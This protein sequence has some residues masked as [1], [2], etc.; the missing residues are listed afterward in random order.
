MFPEV[1]GSSPGHPPSENAPEDVDSAEEPAWPAEEWPNFWPEPWAFFPPWPWPW[2]CIPAPGLPP[3]WWLDNPAYDM[4]ASSNF[5]PAWCT[6][7]PAH[8]I[9]EPA[10]VLMSADGSPEKALADKPDDAAA[11]EPLGETLQAEADLDDDLLD[12]LLA[13]D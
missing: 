12:R 1:R 2:P 7:D 8:P 6:F 3:P 11:D 10:R 5:D 9:G 13:I 4:A